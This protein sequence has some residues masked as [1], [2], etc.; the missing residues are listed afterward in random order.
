MPQNSQNT[1]EF[2]GEL[3]NEVLCYRQETGRGN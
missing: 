3:L 2:F 1:T